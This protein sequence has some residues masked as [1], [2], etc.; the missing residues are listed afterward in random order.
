MVA[1]LYVMLLLGMLVSAFLLGS[2]TTPFSSESTLLVELV[3][4]GLAGRV[5]LL[6]MLMVTT[7]GGYVLLLVPVY[8][9][10]AMVYPAQNSILQENIPEARR[11]DEGT[12]LALA[13]DAPLE[14]GHRGNCDEDVDKPPADQAVRDFI[15]APF[16]SE[17]GARRVE[18]GRGQQRLVRVKVPLRE[19]AQE[20]AGD[21]AL[22]HVA[23]TSC[24]IAA[25]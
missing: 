24:P 1:L 4:G 18:G 7:P 19:R 12:R 22:F 14:L 3:L 2:Q 25:S 21:D 17:G 15:Q 10:G 16:L 23:R 9:F 11:G 8:L 13:C 6:T 5:V 20:L